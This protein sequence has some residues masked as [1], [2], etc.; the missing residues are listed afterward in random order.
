M[1][2]SGQIQYIRENIQKNSRLYIEYGFH[3]DFM[4]CLED[5]VPVFAFKVLFAHA[6]SVIKREN[7][8]EYE[9][10]RTYFL[11]YRFQS[12]KA[13]ENWEDLSIEF[14]MDMITYNE[15]MIEMLSFFGWKVIQIE[16]DRLRE[17]KPELPLPFPKEAADFI[18]P[19]MEA[20]YFDS[21][22]NDGEMDLF[23]LENRRLGTYH[24]FMDAYP[25]QIVAELHE[26]IMDAKIFLRVPMYY[27][28]G[29]F[30]G[31]FISQEGVFYTTFA[32]GYCGGT[33]RYSDTYLISPGCLVMA[34]YMNCLL[35]IAEKEIPAYREFLKT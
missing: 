1:P 33:E 7:K 5:F 31:E 4:G 28:E 25:D 24:L 19:Y 23:I 11:E 30:H 26:A 18:R 8:D 20:V 15:Q 22:H 12:L 13:G 35:E 14:L 2:A 27:W 29:D 21:I 10:F 34:Y 9:K 17:E 6:L 3:T 16:N 32:V